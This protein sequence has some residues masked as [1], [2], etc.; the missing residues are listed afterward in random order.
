MEPVQDFQLSL[1]HSYKTIKVDLTC[2]VKRFHGLVSC[3]NWTLSFKTVSQDLILLCILTR[4]QVL[5]TVHWSKSSFQRFSIF[6]ITNG[7]KEAKAH[8]ARKITQKT[9][10]R[11]P[12]LGLVVL[13]VKISV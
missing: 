13:T 2:Q 8:K 6:T 4:E 3:R 11:G 12:H 10:K 7:E 5:Q 1:F 9:R